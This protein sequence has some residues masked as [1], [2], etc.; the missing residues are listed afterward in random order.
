MRIRHFAA[1]LLLALPWGA[2]PAPAQQDPWVR[3]AAS[4]DGRMTVSVHLQRVRQTGN[5]LNVWLKYHFAGGERT[6]EGR[7][8]SYYISRTE[9]DCANL[10][11]RTVGSVYYTAAG[12]VVTQWDDAY[13]PWRE[14]PPGTVMDAVVTELCAYDWTR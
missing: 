2:S 4:A 14:S 11:H 8:Y 12:E 10:V 13:S 5:R 9:I 7:R 1:A 3:L 6:S